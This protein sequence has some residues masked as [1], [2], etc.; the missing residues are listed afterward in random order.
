MK[1]EVAEA[2]VKDLRETDEP[3][4]K[5]VLY[6]GTGYCCLGRLCIVLGYSFVPFVATYDKDGG[7]RDG[8]YTIDDGS[9][10][11]DFLSAGVVNAAGMISATGQS[12]DDPGKST[13]AE[14]NDGGYTF[15]QI[16]D[17]IERDWKEL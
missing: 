16:A 1:Q 7:Y 17:I 12:S 2:W 5:G 4:T 15:A 9:D 13:L 11:D 14:L 10:C 6:D 3:Q 8:G